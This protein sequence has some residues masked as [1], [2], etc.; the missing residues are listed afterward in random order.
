MKKGRGGL[1]T[2]HQ[3]GQ[4]QASCLTQLIRV[5]AGTSS[6]IDLRHMPLPPDS[7]EAF[8]INKRNGSKVVASN[9]NRKIPMNDLNPDRRVGFIICFRNMYECPGPPPLLSMPQA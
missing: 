1:T 8:E 4:E 6:L 2:A 3:T 5:L 9:E 7:L